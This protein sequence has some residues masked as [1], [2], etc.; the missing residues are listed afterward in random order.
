[1]SIFQVLEV[2]PQK[3][4]RDNENISV[5]TSQ[6]GQGNGCD[7]SWRQLFIQISQKMTSLGQV[8]EERQSSSEGGESVQDVR[9]VR[10]GKKHHH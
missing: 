7:L 4:G 10:L 6:Q 2:V 3:D 9:G 8:K 5:D 1:M